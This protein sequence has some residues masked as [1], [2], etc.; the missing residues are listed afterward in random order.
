MRAFRAPGKSFLQM[1][2]SSANRSRVFLDSSSSGYIVLDC[3]KSHLLGVHISFFSYCCGMG[4]IV[5][6]FH[7]VALLHRLPRHYTGHPVVNAAKYNLLRP[8]SAANTNIYA[9]QGSIEQESSLSLP[10]WTL[11]CTRKAE[12]LPSTT[13]RK[14]EALR[15]SSEKVDL[16]SSAT[17][18]FWLCPPHVQR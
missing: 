13:T 2:E 14:E 11:I 10:H 7:L 6:V 18:G 8:F 16:R 4:C 17:P 15:A 1:Q 9:M 12:E 3:I 5:Y